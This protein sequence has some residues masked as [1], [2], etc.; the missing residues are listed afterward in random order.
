MS[1][2]SRYNVL[3]ALIDEL[4]PLQYQSFY[5]RV[6]LVPV[7]QDKAYL[8]IELPGYQKNQITVYTEKNN[9]FISAKNDLERS[10]RS[11]EYIYNLNENEKVEKVK[12][13][14]GILL[15]DLIKLIPDEYKR[16]NYSVE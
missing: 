1:Q 4:Y 7:S 15:I 14:N 6:R 13:E 2:F 12:Y 16:K 9:L 11:F 5:K 3:S 8:E 10:K